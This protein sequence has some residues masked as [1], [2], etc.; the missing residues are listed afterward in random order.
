MSFQPLNDRVWKPA[1]SVNMPRDQEG[2]APEKGMEA[3]STDHHVKPY[4]SP[5]CGVP[6]FRALN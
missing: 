5:P 1:R 3:L 2:D 6:K 4:S